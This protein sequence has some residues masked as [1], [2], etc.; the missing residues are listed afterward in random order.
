ME[1]ID[2]AIFHPRVI[3]GSCRVIQVKEFSGL[4]HVLR[5]ER[6]ARTRRNC[7]VQVIQPPQVISLLLSQ[8]EVFRAYE[9][10][11]AGRVQYTIL[12]STSQFLTMDNE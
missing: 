8:N 1:G 5:D 12:W 11:A 10:A 9:R 2:L 7:R 4:T 6:G 3:D